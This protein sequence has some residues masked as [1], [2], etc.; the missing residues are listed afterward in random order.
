ML[1]ANS[2]GAVFSSTSPD[3]G[4]DGVVDRFAQIAPKVLVVADGYRYGAEN[5]GGSNCCRSCSGS[6]R[7][8][9]S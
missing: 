9:D 4:V 8:W 5:I 3:F 1:A 7:R 6:L 2:L